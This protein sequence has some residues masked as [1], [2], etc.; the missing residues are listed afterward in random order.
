MTRGRTLCA[1]AQLRCRRRE[2]F[3]RWPVGFVAHRVRSRK[4]TRLM[5]QRKGG[6]MAALFA[7]LR[8]DYSSAP[9]FLNAPGAEPKSP[10]A[11]A[12]MYENAAYTATF[13]ASS[14]GLILSSVSLAVW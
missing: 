6:L 1:N 13:C 7:F 5:K 10:S 12:A 4:R 2:R 14:F 9:S 8:D 11:C 3:R